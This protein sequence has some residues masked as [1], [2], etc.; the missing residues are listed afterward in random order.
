MPPSGP[1]GSPEEAPHPVFSSNHLQISEVALG[2]TD[3]PLVKRAIQVASSDITDILVTA[4]LNAVS[5]PDAARLRLADNVA[6]VTSDDVKLA[7]EILRDP[8]VKSLRDVALNYGVRRMVE[9]AKTAPR[10]GSDSGNF[11]LPSIQERI[12][13]YGPSEIARDRYQKTTL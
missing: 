7:T 6:N 8:G 10:T 2:S 1:S 12:H 4:S 11:G 5:E 9:I 13:S 3:H